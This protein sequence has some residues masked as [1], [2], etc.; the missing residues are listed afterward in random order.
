M[1]NVTRCISIVNNIPIWIYKN[2]YKI[3]TDPHRYSLRSTYYSPPPAACACAAAI[4]FTSYRL[5]LV[6]TSCYFLLGCE[7][8]TW[9]VLYL[10]EVS[11]KFL[12]SCGYACG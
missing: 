12:Y 3:H 4:D 1:L 6:R 10:M 7:Q 11:Q 2:T 9:A 8:G 5:P